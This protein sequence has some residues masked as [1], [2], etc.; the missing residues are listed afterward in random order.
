[1]TKPTHTPTLAFSITAKQVL[2]TKRGWTVF[3]CADELVL[4]DA[5]EARH[6]APPA[7]EALAGPSAPSGCPGPRNG[8]PF[9]QRVEAATTTNQERGAAARSWLISGLLFLQTF[10]VRI[11]KLYTFPSGRATEGR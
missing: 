6:L 1:M 3:W 7:G 8:P 4:V 11:A 9:H 5:I 10:I 2:N